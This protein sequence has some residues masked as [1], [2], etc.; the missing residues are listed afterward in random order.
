[1]PRSRASC[2]RFQAR[3]RPGGLPLGV[4]PVLPEPLELGMDEIGVGAR[5]LRRLGQGI[6]AEA[7]K[8][9]VHHLRRLPPHPGGGGAPG[10]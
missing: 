4:G 3:A 6:G 9:L 2:S 1:M 10:E 5:P 8:V 7:M